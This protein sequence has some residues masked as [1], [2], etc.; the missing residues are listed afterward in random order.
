MGH[1]NTRNH[2][3]SAPKSPTNLNSRPSHLD[4][5]LPGRWCHHQRDQHRVSCGA[6]VGPRPSSA[7]ILGFTL[8][9]SKGRVSSSG[10]D[11]SEGLGWRT[12]PRVNEERDNSGQTLQG[13][14]TLIAPP[15][16][17]H[18]E[19]TRLS[20]RDDLHQNCRLTF[21]K[22]TTMPIPYPPPEILDCTVY[23]IHDEPEILED[24]CPVSE[25]C[26]PRTRKH[27]FAEIEFFSVENLE[28]WKKT[29]PDPSDSP[30]HHTP[31]HWL[32]A[33]TLSC[34]Q[35]QRAVGFKPFLIWYV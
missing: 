14:S 13:L 1:R 29:F 21:W 25:S 4:I 15:C 3:I 35:T 11:T 8:D 23:L 27:L 22:E 32:I 34:R 12:V 6:M 33:L 5:H 24:Y 19:F 26:V 17:L 2:H 9:P 7:P 30:T 16:S 31:P 10:E 28:S 20:E 18:P